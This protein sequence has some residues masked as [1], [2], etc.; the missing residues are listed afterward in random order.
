MMAPVRAVPS[1]RG[2]VNSI[3]PGPV[4]LVAA[5]EIQGASAAAVHAHSLSVATLTVEVPPLVATVWVAG[6]SVYRHGA[7]CDTRACS[8]LMTIAPSRID[9]PSLAATRNDTL[10]GPCP[11]VG[12]RPEIQL[13]L[14]DAV[15]EHSG[16]VATVTLLFPPAASSI[17]GL[18]SST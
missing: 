13:L 5:S 1:L 6:V 8:L 2:T 11:D 17:A 16:W 4:P 15:H 10:P 9:E 18:T 14:V 12:D 3:T 7:R